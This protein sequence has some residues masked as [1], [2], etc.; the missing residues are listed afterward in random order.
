MQQEPAPQG[1]PVKMMQPHAGIKLDL[2]QYFL[3]SNVT[4]SGKA[5]RWLIVYIQAQIPDGL[6]TV[7]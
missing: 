1:G 4:A 2:V 5:L 7:L 6:F 3:H